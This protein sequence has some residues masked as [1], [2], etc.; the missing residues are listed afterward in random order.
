MQPQWK[1]LHNEVRDTL[2]KMENSAEIRKDNDES[3]RFE[4]NPYGKDP[5][6]FSVETEEDRR[7][8]YVNF[9]MSTER[10]RIFARQIL[11][12]CDYVDQNTEKENA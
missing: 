7:T 2:Y 3:L 1:P 11:E 8:V 12:M 5:V 4:Y 10:A 6:N 9:E